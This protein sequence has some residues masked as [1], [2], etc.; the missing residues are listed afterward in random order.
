MTSLGES[1]PHRASRSAQATRPSM[2][3]NTKQANAKAEAEA[4]AKA[5]AAA[6]AEAEAQAEAA[7]I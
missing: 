3:P 1:I 4:G 6:E 7:G 2:H 5:E